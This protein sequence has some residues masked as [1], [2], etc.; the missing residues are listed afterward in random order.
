MSDNSNRVHKKFT[1][2]WEIPPSISSIIWLNPSDVDPKHLLSLDS[3]FKWLQKDF[4]NLSGEIKKIRAKLA[5]AMS[6]MLT[7]DEKSSSLEIMAA[8]SANDKYYNST[9]KYRKVA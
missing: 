9:R 7:Y 1:H 6:P 4:P 5:K 8:A 2:L 3:H